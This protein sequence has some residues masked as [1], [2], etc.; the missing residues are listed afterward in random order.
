MRT[1]LIEVARAA[2]GVA[3][4][5][6]LIAYA[7]SARPSDTCAA[8]AGVCAMQIAAPADTNCR[9]A[10]VLAMDVSIS[11]DQAEDR[12]QREG[13]AAA[14]VSGEVVDAI[15][16]Q[17]GWDVALY[18]FEWAGAQIQRP[19]VPWVMLSSEADVARAA[20]A[21][22][23]SPRS[24]KDSAT[25]LGAALLHA[26]AALD[27]GPSCERQVIDVSGDGKNNAGPEPERA[28]EALPGVTINGLPIG[29][30][31]ED[32]PGY[33]RQAVISGSGAFVEPAVGYGDFRRAIARKLVRETGTPELG[34][35]R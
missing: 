10:L 34:M 35:L 17:P 11:V 20:L 8:T 12:M 2:A 15:L 32:L 31:A 19:I 6:G 16:S 28:R 30:T 3:L 27:A 5:A 4:T 1:V 14:L 25:A 9:L 33:Y 22:A 21:I 18:V 23:E 24:S 29:G 7:N 13:L 26:G